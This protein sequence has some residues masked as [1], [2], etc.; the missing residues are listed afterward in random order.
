LLTVDAERI[1]QLLTALSF[2]SVDMFDHPKAHVEIGAED[3]LGTLE[4]A[5]SLFL[6]ELARAKSELHKALSE[7]AASRDELRVLLDRLPDLVLVHR[8]DRVAWANAISVKTLGYE[9]LGELVGLPVLDLV[10]ARSRATA[11]SYIAK[12][13]PHAERLTELVFLSRPGE[14][15]TVEAAANQPVVFDGIPSRL[16]VARDVTERATMQQK[17]IVADR[18]ASVGL[19]A[20]GVAHE[21]NNPLAWVLNNI[22]IAQKALAND[23]EEIRRT[24][25]A[26]ALEGV[27]QIRTI[28]RELLL[29]S[30][31]DVG[32]SDPVDLRRV[33]ESTLALAKP[34]VERTARLFTEFEA[35]PLVMMSG[36]RLGQVF[37]NLVTNALEALH[38]RSPEESEL[39]VRVGCAGDGRPFLEV[40]DTGMGIPSQQLGRVFEP[41]FTTKPP[42][43]GTG[44]GLAIAQRL[45]VEVGGEITVA[46]EP[47]RG[48]TFRVLLLPV[49]SRDDTC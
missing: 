27:E 18:L 12:A 14:E 16:I 6:T 4:S 5:F 29:F 31:G 19:L 17:L 41:F 23:G 34:Q 3:E 36:A 20:A 39:R 45:I 43:Q 30:R 48:T 44:L 22:E 47:G 40:S 46:S 11:A 26:T 8:E 28:I 38:G 2:A 25:L 33:V 35:A 9:S 10:A 7:T 24:A 1:E 37:L 32:C 21:V 13:E 49:T 15:I 42:G